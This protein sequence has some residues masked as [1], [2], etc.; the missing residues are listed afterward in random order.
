MK[1]KL[2]LYNFINDPNLEKLDSI[3]NKFNPFNVLGIE[4]MEIRHSNF[5]AWLLAPKENHNLGDYFLKKFLTKVIAEN[6]DNLNSEIDNTTYL[7]DF[8]DAVVYREKDHIDILIVSERNKLVVIIENKIKA[9][10][11]R[12]QLEN[13]LSFINEQYVTYNRIPIYLTLYGD[14]PEN[15]PEYISVSY[16]SIIYPLIKDCLD[17]KKDALPK[18][19]ALFINYYLKTLKK[20]LGMDKEIEKMCIEIYNAHKNA[21]ER[22]FETVEQY[23]DS[24][25]PVFEDFINNNGDLKPFI[26][27]R[28][29]LWFLPNRFV[30]RTPKNNAGWDIPYPYGFWFKCKSDNKISFHIEVGPFIDPEKRVDFM[31]FLKYKGYQIRDES[32]RIESINTKI[33]TRVATIEKIED[34]EEVLKNI[35]KIYIDSKDEISKFYKVI[36]E[37]DFSSNKS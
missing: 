1:E 20:L 6:S 16:E 13:Y 21:I 26:V 10:E 9:K 31:N 32:K 3:S 24:L 30:E 29:R 15:C 33:H 8:S 28:R 18:E 35:T 27:S 37:Y 11:S 12:Y 34:K 17:L 5:L 19:I 22:I 23:K 36:S 4:K 7:I 14:E 25:Q 2:E